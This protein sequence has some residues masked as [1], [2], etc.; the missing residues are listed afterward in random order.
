LTTVEG[1]GFS[2]PLEVKGSQIQTP[3]ETGFLQSACSE[4]VEQAS[5]ISDRGDMFKMR[6][7]DCVLDVDLK[8]G[9]S[10]HY[11]TSTTVQVQIQVQE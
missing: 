9:A 7:D 2:S 11:S 6:L 10:V 3:A 5:F 8:A 4:L 1:M